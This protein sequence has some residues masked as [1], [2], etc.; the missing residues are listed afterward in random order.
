[1]NI[2]KNANEIKLNQV[3]I[4]DL[5]WSHIQQLVTDVMIPYQEDILED[6]IPNVEKS[7]AIANF[8]IAAGLQEG[9]YYGMVFQDSDVA[10]WLEG[11]AYSLSIKPDKLLEAKADNIIEII[12]KAQQ[13]DGYLNTYFT[14]KEPE[15]RWQNLFEG[16]ELYCAGH[17][18]EAAVAYYET[19]GKDQLLKV[20]E[21]MADHI[22]QRFG[23]DKIRGIPGHQEVEIGLMRM[24]HTT[25]K[26]K[27]AELAKYFIDERGQQPDFFEK[28]T[29][30]R[31]WNIF[32]ELHAE[33]N[34]YN[35]SYA[36]VYEQNEVVGHSV[37]AVYMYTAMADLAASFQDEKLFTACKRLWNN[38][39]NK[40]MY[41]TGSIGS[42]VEGE[43]FTIDYDLPNDT[44]YAETCA[45]IALVFFAKQMLDIEPNGEFADIMERE[46]YNGILSGMQLDGK[47][48][49]YV[50]PLEVDPDISGKLYGHRHVLPQR[51]GWYACACCPPNLVRLMA[52]LGKY[53]WSENEST[54]YSH[55]FIGQEA[56]LK[57]ADITI[58]SEYP[59]KGNIQYHVH[60]LTNEPFTLAIHIP[61]HIKM[62]TLKINNQNIS[63]DDKLINGYLYI[64]QKW[65]DDTLQ[66]SFDISVRKI[67]A[68]TK[69]KEDAGCVA[70]MRG[71]LV[72]CFEGIDNGIELQALRI[73]QE[74]TITE[75]M[76]SEGPL[77]GNL[78]LKMNGIRMTGT[79]E[80]YSETPLQKEEVSLSAIPYYTWG[81][82]GLNQMRVW[83]LEE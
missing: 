4:Q 78:I 16:H 53:A 62:F 75:D 14:I 66:I 24:Y 33:N 79:N 72:Y 65:G 49:F 26:K 7:H 29:A 44:A 28:E 12:A 54:I 23:K 38:M 39:V 6:R 56:R 55:L 13:E 35:Q 30:E 52:S 40:K 9:T 59:W 74:L 3:K 57:K 63:V 48:F 50:N 70:L 77:Q 15:H 80:L 17:M 46:L 61:S 21:K 8:R 10:K 27:Y 64:N 69:V 18:M 22:D 20:M 11:V 47:N 45:S 1:M 36:T 68:N 42:T 81:N 83:M 25:G 5:F 19:T 60:S 71:P 58:K 82:R 73:P 32:P 31:N 2:K 67:Y 51:P 37:R 41:L 43:S 76:C 34:Y